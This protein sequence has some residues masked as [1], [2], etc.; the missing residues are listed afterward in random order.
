MRLGNFIYKRSTLVPLLVAAVLV[1]GGCGSDSE[2]RRKEA[3]ASEQFAVAYLQEKQPAKALVEIQKA[4]ALDP[5]SA[6]IKNTYALA[7]WSRREYALA[8]KKFLE[9]VEL[10][11]AFSEAWNNLGAFY[12]DQARYENAASA[13]KKA[14]ENVYYSTSERALTNLGWAYFK[15]GRLEEAKAKLS[16][17]AEIAPTF[18]LAQKDLGMVLQEMGDHR[19]AIARFDRTIKLY[20][21]DQETFFQKGVSQVKLG[22]K[23]GASASFEE[24]WKLGPTTDIG[25]SARNYLDI[26]K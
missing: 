4:E 2:V 26:L 12:L 7:Y 6:E 11:P 22:D 15:L 21:L 23:A 3:K 20:S 14:L 9:A 10:D 19:G 17:A 8:E 24:A 1:A 25:K 13:F 5:K 16:E 18:A